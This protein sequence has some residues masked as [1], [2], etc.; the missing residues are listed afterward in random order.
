M[1]HTSDDAT[2]RLKLPYLAA[3]QAQKHVTVNEAL[4]ALDGLV[5]TAV[6]TA[7]ATAEPPAPPDGALYILPEGRTGPEWALHPPGSLLRFADGGWTR[8]AAGDG[9]IAYVRDTGAVLFRSGGLWRPLGQALGHLQNVSR[10]GLNTEADAANPFAARLNKALF[11]ATPAAA[12]GDGDLRVTFNKETPADV[13]SL[14]FQSAYSGRA[15]LGLAG[16]DDLQLKVSPDG[17]VWRE[18]LR[19]ERGT[20]RLWAG[21]LAVERSVTFNLLPDSGRFVS[22]ANNGVFAGAAYAAPTWLN[23]SGGS[24]FAGHARF[25]HDNTDYGGA[26][27]ALDPHVRELIDLIRPPT[28]RRYGAEWWVL[29]IVRGATAVEPFLID[30]ET[31]G[32][33]ATVSIV[34]LPEKLTVGYYLRVLSGKASIHPPTPDALSIDGEAHGSTTP[35]VVLPGEGWRYVNLL[36]RSNVYG[37]E[38]NL[39]GLRATAGA[40]LL[41]AMPRIVFGHVRLGRTLG[42]MPNGRVFG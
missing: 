32:L 40:E 39:L 30:G 4:S 3:G 41:L 31:F 19:V 22:A 10:L 17:A 16:D 42:V 35:R 36:S 33:G 25:L 18:G 27:G 20:G 38:Y 5:Q 14:L 24:T 15:E 1:P 2:P 8:L 34:P 23:P 6:E 21:D 9:A 28:A 29:K 12:G 26:A 7:S 11:T 13:L 37:Y